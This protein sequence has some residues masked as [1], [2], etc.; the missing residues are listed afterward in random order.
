MARPSRL[1]LK[2]G[3]DHRMA[4]SEPLKAM[5]GADRPGKDRG[6]RRIAGLASGCRASHHPPSTTAH[7]HHPPPRSQLPLAHNRS[8]LDSLQPTTTKRGAAFRSQI[9]CQQ[10]ARSP[11]SPLNIFRGG[12]PDTHM[13]NAMLE[14]RHSQLR[15]RRF[16]PTFLTNNRGGSYTIE[17]SDLTNLAEGL[18]P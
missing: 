11:H 6:R 17:Q 14:F 3:N 5:L 10:P 7:Y 9:S 12:G 18:T 2:I 1:L 15:L 16:T 4:H 8:G 13:P